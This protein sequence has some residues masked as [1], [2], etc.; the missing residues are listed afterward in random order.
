MPDASWE[1]T[2]TEKEIAREGVLTQAGLH[3]GEWFLRNPSMQEFL[4][5]QITVIAGLNA[6]CRFLS[7]IVHQNLTEG[8]KQ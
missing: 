2:E 5:Q 1:V 3:L 7:N 6:Q 8:D 4:E